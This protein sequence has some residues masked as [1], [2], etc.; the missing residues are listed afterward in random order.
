D[1]SPSISATSSVTLFSS[2]VIGTYLPWP[3]RS[4]SLV[5][6][7]GTEDQPVQRR[8]S[9]PVVNKRMQREQGTLIKLKERKRN[10]VERVID[11]IGSSK[12]SPCRRYHSTS[13][14]EAG[15]ARSR[16]PASP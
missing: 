10:E 16:C 12:N 15:S 6:N 1:L 9:P 8:G 3:C 14:G 2:V 7:T 13:L 5:F 4:S 11:R